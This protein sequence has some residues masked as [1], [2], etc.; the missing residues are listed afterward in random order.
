MTA[1]CV[2]RMPVLSRERTDLEIRYQE[3]SDQVRMERSRRSDFELEEMEFDKVKK[4][5]IK[6]A[7]EEDIAGAKV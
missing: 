5:R 2:Q 3:M 6:K 1:V 4:A 7:Q